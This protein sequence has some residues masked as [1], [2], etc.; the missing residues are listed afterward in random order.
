MWFG[1]LIQ[2]L[3]LICL[4]LTD[5]IS[6]H[7]HPPFFRIDENTIARKPGAVVLFFFS[8]GFHSLWLT[9]ARAK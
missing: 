7:P 9:I 6:T 5:V 2:V 8:F 4:A 1:E 3:P